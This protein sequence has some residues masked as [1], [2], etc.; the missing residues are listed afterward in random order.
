[1]EQ[2][3]RHRRERDKY[4]KPTGEPVGVTFFL[5]DELLGAVQRLFADFSDRLR[6]R[7]LGAQV[8]SLSSVL[9]PSR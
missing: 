5:L 6:P 3:N 2:R 7:L 8:G 1:M 9:R 4:A